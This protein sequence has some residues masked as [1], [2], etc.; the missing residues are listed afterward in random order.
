MA[1][2]LAGTQFFIEERIYRRIEKSKTW[3][4]VLAKSAMACSA[5]L[6]QLRRAVNG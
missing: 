6:K 1:L 2:G 4:S 5:F 3:E